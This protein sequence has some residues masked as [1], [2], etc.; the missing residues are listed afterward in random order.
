MDLFNT[1]L[2]LAGVADK[3]P[4]DRYIDGI[5]QT[6]PIRMLPI[7]QANLLLLLMC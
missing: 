3:I 2:T 4:S 7:E 6:M 5:D 1:S